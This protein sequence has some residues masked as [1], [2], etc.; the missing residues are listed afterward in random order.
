MNIQ[1]SIT[2]L[3]ELPEPQRKIILWIV[4]IILGLALLFWW[5]Q[6]LKTR[7]EPLQGQEGTVQ[8]PVVNIQEEL[9]AL[10]NIDLSPTQEIEEQLNGQ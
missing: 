2:R 8:L 5:A 9:E 1:K 6:G 10:E 7:F 4:V 3:Q